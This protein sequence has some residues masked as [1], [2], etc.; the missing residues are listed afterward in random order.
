MKILRIPVIIACTA[1]VIASI[2]APAA[3]AQEVSTPEIKSSQSVI[4]GEMESRRIFYSMDAY[5]RREPAS[6]TKIMTL[7]L[8][9]EAVE[10]GA[11][12]MDDMVTASSRC[13]TGLDFTSST[14]NIHEGETMSLKDLMYCTALASAN[15][16]C[17]IIAE[18]ISGSVESFVDKMNE[19]AAELG[20]SGTHFANTH[21]MPDPEHYTTA[22]DLF[23]IACCGM[24]SEL[25]ARLVS[26]AEY[27]TAA[28]NVNQGRQLVNSNALLSAR[29]P[30][31]SYPYDGAVGIKTGH[32]SAAGYCL[33]AA[34]QRGGM[35]MVSIV[36][37]ADGDADSRSFDCF[38]DTAALLDWC[39]DNCSMRVI[40]EKNS[41]AG[42]QPVEIDGKRGGLEL[43]CAEDVTALALNSLDPDS[44][45]KETVL[46]TELLTE[47]P[48]EGTTLGSV[49]FIDP[50]DGTEYGTVS[51]VAGAN[52]QYE[53]P[54][55]TSAP[56]PQ[57]LQAKQKT[58]I[59][60]VCALSVLLLL[61]FILLMSRKYSRRR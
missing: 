51:L 22:R 20:C 57:G 56:T 27:T 21:G 34:A 19:K 23:I 49:S 35:T 9:V 44:L 12:S 41:I 54:E 1:A 14:S 60:I 48:A 39:F 37:G 5:S 10:Q 8:A 6:L 31:G 50:E 52:V 4:V 59:V 18:H 15:E 30:Y 40:A 16:A 42:L 55:Q 38:P 13:K 17:N 25:F 46:L 28:T 53:E 7:L 33:A 2:F 11:V 43:L 32:T 29:S 47:L 61:G 26:T 36:L 45:K 58:A 3:L 24:R